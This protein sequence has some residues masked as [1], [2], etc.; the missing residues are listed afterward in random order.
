MT[1]SEIVSKY[2]AAKA[3]QLDDLSLYYSDDFPTPLY[4]E[5]H[6]NMEQEEYDYLRK[7]YIN[8]TKTVINKPLNTC[9][10]IFNNG[11]YSLNYANDEIKKYFESLKFTDWLK[12]VYL[13]NSIIYSESIVSIYIDPDKVVTDTEGNV[14]KNERPPVQPYIILPENI[15]YKSDEQFIF[16]VH[17]DRK[18]NYVVLSLTEYQLYSYDNLSKNENIE[19]ILIIPFNTPEKRWMGVVGVK[20]LMETGYRNLSYF[21]PAI[22]LLKSITYNVIKRQVIET[23]HIFPTRWF[24]D[25]DCETCDGGKK[26][27]FDKDDC[28]IDCKTCGGT[29]KV[30]KFSI[31]RDIRIKLRENPLQPEN[32]IPTPPAGNIS[33]STLEVEYLSK[34]IA[35]DSERAFDFIEGN[36]SS[37]NPKGSD[38][39]LGKMIDR[40]E[41]YAFLVHLT[42]D[43]F[44]AAAW[45]INTVENIVFPEVKEESTITTNNDFNVVSE[46]ELNLEFAKLLSE[47]CATYI[48]QEK[49]KEIYTKRG[50]IENFELVNKYYRYVPDASIQ[51][52]LNNKLITSISAIMHY[53]VMRWVELGYSEKEMLTMAEAEIPKFTLDN[54][55]NNLVDGQGLSGDS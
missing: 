28:K 44:E 7:S 25:Q 35:E 46:T 2:N 41:K 43:V 6:P 19:P 26:Q 48:L 32:N 50:K 22:P 24:M 18:Y 1:H 36:Y 9:K 5:K 40:E 4:K 55:T 8:E 31:F 16:K 13:E 17:G 27:F 38:T 37:S 47:G 20:K 39:A 52:Q 29:N 11:N 23:R 3:K 51:Y 42:N 34:R 10:R 15:L 49:L 45:I 30:P 14:K 12:N 33:S 21:E 53:N 54:F